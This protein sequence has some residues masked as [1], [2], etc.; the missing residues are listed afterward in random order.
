VTR[1]AEGPTAAAADEERR[2]LTS[3]Q[4]KAL[5]MSLRF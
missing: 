1:S 2:R 3:R 5:S 4:G